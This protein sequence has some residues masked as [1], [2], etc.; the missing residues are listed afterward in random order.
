MATINFRVYSGD[1]VVQGSVLLPDGM[2]LTDYLNDSASVSVQSARLY[3]LDDG[4]EVTAGDIELAAQDIWAVEPPHDASTRPN[5]HVPTRTTRIEL[6]LTPYVVSG[7]LHA[8]TIGQGDPVAGMHRRRP[9]V[10]LT[11][12]NI[13]FYFAGREISRDVDV[14]VINREQ[15]SITPVVSAGDAAQGHALS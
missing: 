14:L 13:R 11:E 4:R 9:M 5:R 2:R 15:A 3:A 10:A 1:C 8:P 12:A 6:N 7:N